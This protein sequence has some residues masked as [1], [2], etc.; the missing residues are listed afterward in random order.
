ME[1]KNKYKNA[2]IILSIFILLSS[3]IYLVYF[4]KYFPTEPF[5]VPISQDLNSSIGF[6]LLLSLLP[7]ALTQRISDTWFESVD[8]NVPRFLQD[9]TEDVKSG[10]SLIFSLQENAEK[11]YGALS[12]PLQKSLTYFKLTADLSASMNMLGKMLQRP[13]ARQM[14]TILIEA[15]SSGGGVDEILQ[16]SVDLFKNIQDDRNNRKIKTKPYIIVVYI[17]LILFLAVSWVIL[18]KFLIPMSIQTQ[19]INNMAGLGVG[20]LEMGYYRSI[21]FWSAIAESVIGGL[22][23]GKISKGK[24]A[25]G[26]IH[27]VI[28]LTISVF[29]FTFFM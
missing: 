15:Y 28:L 6:V 18:N 11:D 21:L 8:H 27:V 23:A 22:V 29:F 3:I 19:S 10:Q 12:K 5:W 7:V 16:S 24:T 1:W 26:L 20:F 4:K 17:S 14:S 13:V 9:V 25:S 2:S